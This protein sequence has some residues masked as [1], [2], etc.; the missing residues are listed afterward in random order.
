[1]IASINLRPYEI[2]LWNLQDSFITVLKAPNNEYQ[3]TLEEPTLTNINNQNTLE[4]STL[5][6]INNQGTLEQPILKNV[7]DGTQELTF[8]IPMYIN[9]FNGERI[10]NPIWYNVINGNLIANMRKLKVIFNK[11]TKDESVF[12]LLI[13]KVTEQ[14]E[15][16][17][18]ICEVTCEGLPFHELGKQGIKCQLSYEVYEAD[19]LKWLEECQQIDESDSE[20]KI[21]P[22]EPKNNLSY[23]NEKIGFKKWIDGE[24][25][26][27]GIW[28]YDIQMDWSAYAY[29][30]SRSTDKVY[31]EGYVSSWEIDENTGKITPGDIKDY[32]E[33][34]RIVE[35][36]NSNYYN[37]TQDLAKEFGVFCR[38][39]YE[40]DDNYHIIA[41]KIIYYNNFINDKEGQIDFSYPYQSSQISREM[42]STDIVTKMYVETIEDSNTTMRDIS[43][44]NS[45][46]NL[47]KEDYLL[48]FDYMYQIGAIAKD[49]YDAVFEYE[50][51]IRNLNIQ[52]IA[53]D[54]YILNKNMQLPKLEA[55]LS[56]AKAG[57]Q[58]AI[59]GINETQALLDAITSSDGDNNGIIENNVRTGYLIPDNKTD[60]SNIQTFSLNITEKGVIQDTIKIYDSYDYSTPSNP[61]DEINHALDR[62]EWVYEY[63]EFNNLIKINNIKKKINNDTNLIYLQYDYSPELYYKRIIDIWTKRLNL[64]ETTITNNTNQIENINRTINEKNV[65]RSSLLQEKEELKLNFNKFMGP[66]LREGSWRPENNNNSYN[67]KKGGYNTLRLQDYTYLTARD[68]ALGLFWDTDLSDFENTAYGRNIFYKE[69]MQ[70]T[71]KAYPCLKIDKDMLKYI[72]RHKNENLCIIYTYNSNDPLGKE[73]CPLGS[74]CDFVFIRDQ[75]SSIVIDNEEIEEELNRIE[76]F[77]SI[78]VFDIPQNYNKQSFKENTI[79]GTIITEETENNEVK[80]IIS[81]T[82]QFNINS[83][84]DL[85]NDYHQAVYPRFKIN[86][87]E[88]ILNYGNDNDET[89]LDVSFNKEKLIAYKDYSIL[90]TLNGTFISFNPSKLILNGMLYNEQDNYGNIA[91][92]IGIFYYISTASTAYYLDAKEILKEN[93]VPKV[94]YNISTSVFNTE[95]MHTAYQKLNRIININDYELKF[96]NVQGY[97]SSLEL[98]LDAPWE[99]SIEVKNYKTKFEDLFTSIIASTEAMQQNANVVSAAASALN[100]DGSIKDTSLQ[101]A[102]ENANLNYSFN[103][104]A[105]TISND[106]GIESEN[107]GGVVAMRKGGIFTATDKDENG[108]WIWNSGITPQGINAQMITVGQLDTNRIVVQAGDQIK[109]Q[110]NDKGLYAYKSLL[111]DKYIQDLSNTD[112]AKLNLTDDVDKKQ[113]V[114]HNADGLFLRVENGAKI[115]QANPDYTEDSD[116]P[117]AIL[118]TMEKSVDRV[119]ISWNGLVLRNFNGD[120]VFKADPNTGNLEITGT[121]VASGGQ[122]GGWIVGESG[123][124]AQEE[125]EESTDEEEL[126]VNAQITPKSGLDLF[127]K[128]LINK[129]ILRISTPIM[130]NKKTK[131]ITNDANNSEADSVSLI[132]FG[133]E[134]GNT[135]LAFYKGFQT[136][137]EKILE[138]KRDRVNFYEDIYLTNGTS[139]IRGAA[140]GVAPLNNSGLIDSTYLPSYV[141]DVLTFSN[142]NSFPEIGEDGKIYVDNSTNLTYRWSGSDYIEISKSLALGETSS[143]AYRGDRGA[144]A[145][146]HAVTNK[147]EAFSNGFYKFQ[148]NTEGHVISAT[149]IS[150]SDIWSLNQTGKVLSTLDFTQADKDKLDGIAAQA[151]NYTAVIGS[152]TALTPNFGETYTIEQVSQNTFGQINLINRNITIPNTVVSSTT[153]GL[154]LSTDK[155]KLDTIAVNAQVNILEGI[156]L[157]GV[158]LTPDQNKN[159]NIDLSNKMNTSAIT[160]LYDNTKLYKQNELCIYEN[161]IYKAN[162]DFELAEDWDSTHWD[163]I[164]IVELLNNKADKQ[165]L[166]MFAPEYDEERIYLK[167]EFC[168][169]NY[170]L[171]KA[172]DDFDEAESWNAEH[173]TQTT[174]CEELINL[175]Q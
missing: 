13:T 134:H 92:T 23:W 161:N 43:I 174:L 168:I 39:A 160:A 58:A 60:T 140:N 50:T 175:R 44:I 117:R 24:M 81:S 97:I 79:L 150:W 56:L 16:G 91:G 38:Y 115:T 131:A 75:N 111:E 113:Y 144:I 40:Y 108:E 37:I 93:S 122:I 170:A 27:P 51:N 99:D 54:E 94:S 67:K 165:I 121:V 52:I 33:K 41:R 32:Q 103:N 164:T 70:E 30:N 2:S 137:N 77:P 147:G 118:H 4:E 6:N 12:E 102:L 29:G 159:I 128:L 9:D 139:L 5:I 112:R 172:I 125:S 65:Q 10:E 72:Q 45:E 66:A 86:E 136:T 151:G 154:M 74:Q 78:I 57:K 119:E 11:G 127:G 28:Y 116:L 90:P 20:N 143:T 114:V 8:S 76:I 89:N 63:D 145:Y 18:L 101:S 157:D 123:L 132:S 31:E 48:N 98:H 36:S 107:D 104:G 105:L 17:Q 82:Y 153:N 87:N 171:Y 169:H 173:W 35:L 26:N 166:Q 68:Y 126:V 124:I 156:T 141:D 25:H 133:D 148:T 129:D 49:Q 80:I 162:I 120:D 138:I 14:H 130:R 155:V 3:G 53:I 1:M 146:T 152:S 100:P 95:F 42:D 71:E 88:L 110:L 69:D 21:Y 106:K 22:E 55:E 167:D 84:I 34:Y 96:E 47:S 7:D 83:W 46:A 85:N 15:D 135:T 158:A 109:F 59:K 61:F 163:N 62:D 142:S 19:Y 73:Y 149:A 64:D